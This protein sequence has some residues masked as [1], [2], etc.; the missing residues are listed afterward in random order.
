M[1]KNRKHLKLLSI[2][3]AVIIGSSTITTQSKAFAL[4]ESSK[5]VNYEAEKNVETVYKQSFE[6]DLAEWKARSGNVAIDSLKYKDGSKSLKITDR[7]ETWHGP[8]IDFTDILEKGQAYHFSAYVMYDDEKGLDNQTFNLQ[9][10]NVVNGSFKYVTIGSVTAQK[11]KWTKIEGDYRIPKTDV[12]S[13]YS[14]DIELAYKPKA[15][16]EDSD[17]IDFYIDDVSVEKCDM[18]EKDFQRDLKALRKEYKNYFPIGTE[19]NPDQLYD[20]IHPEF[21]AHQYNAIVG[22]NC[23]KVDALQPTEGDFYWKDADSLR[24]Y[25][26]A[27]NMIFRGHTLLWHSQVPDWFFQDKNDP[28]KPAS[29]ELLI[30]RMKTHINTVVSRYKDDVDYWDVVNEVLS[31]KEGLRRNDENSKWASIIG[32]V[33]GDGYDDDFIELAFR[34]AKAANPKGKL[35][36]ND[37][38]LESSK[39][40]TDEMYNLVKRL[41]Q[42]GVPIDGI[43]LQMHVSMYSPDSQVVKENMDK[44]ASLK[45]FK[46]DGDF[47]LQVTEMDMS[48]YSGSGEQMKEPTKE[49]LAQ[50]A[51]QY[52]RLF[53]VFKE[54]NKKGNLNLVMLWGNSD[55]DTWLD[56]FPVHNRLDAPMLFDRD[57]QAKTAYYALVD[58]SKADIYKQK[59]KAINETPNINESIDNKWS[60]VKAFEANTFVENTDG[61]TAKVKTMWDKDNLY[62][63]ADVTDKTVS[64]NDSVTFYV[65]NGSGNKI[66]YNVSRNEISYSDKFRCKSDNDGYEVQWKLPLKEINN[67]KPEVGSK[68]GFD[69]KIEDEDSNGKLNSIAVWNDYSSNSPEL[70]NFGE[71]Q[72]DGK[73]KYVEAKRGTPSIDGEIDEIWNKA[74]S[75]NTDLK[76]EGS[77]SA[78]AK[79]RTLWDD[80]YLYVLLEVKDNNLN[81]DSDKEHEQD[82]VEVFI[83]ENNARTPSYDGDDAQ[84]RINF[85]NKQSGGGNTNMDKFKSATK[86]TD[87]GYVVEIAIPLQNKPYLNEFMGFDAQV[88]NAE[89]GKRIGVTMWSDST[90]MTWSTMSNIGNIKLVE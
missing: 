39:R 9:F 24:D 45:Q 75:F 78:K 52:K 29:R 50:Q 89:D 44:L 73:V 5:N 28:T 83:D 15:K 17:K 42:K 27:N 12:V 26:K 37:Y 3:A 70:Q 54:E 48:M 10:E 6:N 74:N 79:V 66:K 34:Y 1:I 8:I 88:N 47:I 16:T 62:V 43:G 64:N 67:L 68:I 19:I 49:I 76:V 31:D 90:G 11:G 36:I 32:D 77:D 35:I 14:M 56:N 25:A 81:K 69:I 72:L 21:I 18:P 84:Y 58:P 82:S 51:A 61:A 20:D 46:K 71:I 60:M 86:V 2:M 7:Q 80:N 57:L 59:V 87:D 53:D 85:E 13:K 30:E 23:M 22:G 33:D 38:G 65:D 4:E 55:D 40:K 63:L 41:L